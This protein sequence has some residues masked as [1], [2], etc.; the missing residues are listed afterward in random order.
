MKKVGSLLLC[1]AILLLLL[2]G[3]G[4]K[5]EW[6]AATC[7]AP[8]HCPLCGAT[9]GEPAVHTW[10]DATCTAPKTCAVCGAT[11]GDPLG[12]TPGE[13]EKTDAALLG[14]KEEQRCTACNEILATRV[15]DR[16]KK[17]AVTVLTPSGLVMTANQFARHL[18]T[19][20]PENCQIGSIRDDQ[21]EITG[22][23]DVNVYYD[24]SNQN[25]KDN[26]AFYGG[27]A[28]DI[29]YLLPF[30]ISAIDPEIADDVRNRAVVSAYRALE[31]GEDH[32][33]LLHTGIGYTHYSAPIRLP[34]MTIPASYAFY[35]FTL[36]L[37]LSG[38]VTIS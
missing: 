9:E 21:I 31:N 12:H 18:I 13:W 34:S 11:E 4:C 19:Y 38:L 8:R 17:E 5:H 6:V 10:K 32:M 24:A 28:D 15:A 14:G 2:P 29:N 16:G 23:V 7:T 35:F 26:I 20:L 36:Q 22:A 30:L 1:A 3:C 33:V 37:Y 27:S 25:Y